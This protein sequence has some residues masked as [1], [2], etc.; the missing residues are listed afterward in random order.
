MTR[1]RFAILLPV[2]FVLLTSFLWFWSRAQYKAFIRTTI[3]A[4]ESSPEWQDWP[5]VWTDYTPAPLQLAG[6]LNVP[7]A[8]FAHPMY[9][10]V[11]SDVKVL[12][13]LALLLGVAT[14]WGYVGWTW[15]V[16][17]P[18][19]NRWPTRITAALGIPFSVFLL[20]ASF[21]MYHVGVVYQASAVLWAGAI[22]WHS[23]RVLRRNDRNFPIRPLT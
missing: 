22:F 20:P 3:T 21:S 18:R 12:K 1:L 11:H 2:L 6:A 23:V 17:S 9:S 5:E 15:D 16:R 19:R 4:N 13:L 10:L 14:Q 8:T 7:V